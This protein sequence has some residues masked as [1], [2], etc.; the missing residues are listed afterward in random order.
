VKL[1]GENMVVGMS[2]VKV[3]EKKILKISKFRLKVYIS[4]TNMFVALFLTIFVILSSSV[5][6]IPTGP[7]NINPG[8]TSRFP[9]T[10]ATN[11]S[12]IA[13]NVT[14]LNFE[15]N[16]VTNTWQGY[17]GNISGSILLGNADNQTMYDWTSASPNGEIYATRSDIPVS[18]GVIRCAVEAEINAEDDALGVNQSVDQD[19]VSRTFLNTTSFNP[20]YVGNV[21]IN[22][23]QNCYA[24]HLNDET[25]NPSSDFQEV[26]LHD[27]SALVYTAIISQ[28]STG[29]DGN[30]HDFQMLVGE[31]G[32]NGDSNPTPYYF[33][34]ELGQ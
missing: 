25:G 3:F 16:S 29:F 26:L 30:T 31:D 14:A 4:Q 33:Y 17:F 19:S 24:L 34:V 28:D 12:A 13:G 32:H 27:G 7:S 1:I 15:S 21:N 6:A 5:I 9:V 23:T 2:Y 10:S 22:T 20:F 8:I 18:W 11:V